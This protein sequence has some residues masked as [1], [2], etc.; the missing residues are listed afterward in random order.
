MWSDQDWLESGAP[1]S[2]HNRLSGIDRALQGIRAI[3]DLLALNFERNTV[4]RYHGADEAACCSFYGLTDTHEE[5]LYVA[6]RVLLDTTEGPL[7]ELRNNHEYCWG[8]KGAPNEC[9]LPCQWTQ[10]RLHAGVSLQRSRP[11]QCWPTARV[12]AIGHHQDSRGAPSGCGMPCPC[13]ISCDA[14]PRQTLLDG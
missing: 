3:H 11:A 12:S 9:A 4:L 8:G 5:G 1:P 6:M 14:A 13:G 10:S 2:I 7:R